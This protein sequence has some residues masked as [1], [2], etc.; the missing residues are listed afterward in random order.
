MKI[1]EILIPLGL[2]LI[3]F[4]LLFLTIKEEVQ[5]RVDNK[6]KIAYD[7]AWNGCRTLY[8]NDYKIIQNGKCIETDSKT[9]CQE[10]TITKLK[11][12]E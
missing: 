9:I 12:T 3:F 1:A 10:F 5:A 6:Y 7:C 4:G 11:G 8:T 2:F